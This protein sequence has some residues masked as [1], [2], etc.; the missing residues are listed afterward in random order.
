MDKKLISALVAGV[1][2]FGVFAFVLP[3][4]SSI[5]VLRTAIVERE[6]ALAEK[7]SIMEKISS[8][9]KEI[10]SGRTDI[11]KLGLLIPPAKSVPEL[12]STIEAAAA[13]SGL[14]VAEVKFSQQSSD[15]QEASHKKINTEARLTGSYVSAFNFLKI[16]EQNLRLADVES[17]NI[18]QIPGGSF[19][20]LGITVKFS[21]YYLK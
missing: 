9:N 19:S 4:Y 17:V 15:N 5:K 8:L 2:I 21:A 10:E 11:N 7:R 3:A 16:I 14:A 13:Q 6:A 12:I 18:T 1:S 20:N